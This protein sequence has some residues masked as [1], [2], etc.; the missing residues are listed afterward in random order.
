MGVVQVQLPDD[1]KQAIDRQIAGG[2]AANETD[3][4]VEAARLYADHL[5]AEDDIIA[6]A[7]RADADVAAG[8]VVMVATPESGARVGSDEPDLEHLHAPAAS[9]DKNLLSGI[10][11]MRMGR[12]CERP[13]RRYVDGLRCCPRRNNV[14]TESRQSATCQRD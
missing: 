12:V 5:D 13:I 6:M 1:L 10:Q 2:H 3:F 9:L 7:A 8:R 11:S 14:G 4:L